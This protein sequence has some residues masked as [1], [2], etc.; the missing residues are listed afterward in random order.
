MDIVNIEEHLFRAWPALQTRHYDGWVLRFA[1]GYTRRANS[2]NPIYSS[3]LDID[4]KIRFC[5]AQYGVKTTFRLTP[6][7]HPTDLDKI[8]AER[9]YE[10][11]GLVNVELLDLKDFTCKPEK[12]VTVYDKLQES[13]FRAYVELNNIPPVHVSTLRE[14]FSNIHGKPYFLGIKEDDKFIC[15]GVGVFDDNFVGLFGIATASKY[16]KQGNA[17]ALICHILDR[18]KSENV[19]YAYLQVVNENQNAIE[20]YTKLGFE[21][22]YQY[23]YRV[24][25][26]NLE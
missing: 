5:E 10:R 21:Q 2:V 9:G 7:T 16:R 17:K 8:L 14:M 23:W 18:A 25:H 20:L 22:A 24:K 3:S 4:E 6:T 12:S 26:R 1:N 11:E 19:E 13:W 15:V